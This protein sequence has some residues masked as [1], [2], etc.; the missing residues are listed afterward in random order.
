MKRESVNFD[1]PRDV[2]TWI[3]AMRTEVEEMADVVHEVC[4][5]KRKRV[6]SREHARSEIERAAANLAALLRAGQRG[7]PPHE[8]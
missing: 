1:D 5:P 7:L 6:L 2:R 4:K 8:A 3:E